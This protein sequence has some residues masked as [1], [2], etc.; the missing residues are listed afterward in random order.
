VD[1]E[2]EEHR[3]R[4]STDLRNQTDSLT[5]SRLYIAAVDPAPGLAYDGDHLAVAA[6]LTVEVYLD[7]LPVHRE[8]PPLQD[9]DVDA[10][11]LSQVG[12][13][14]FPSKVFQRVPDGI[15]ESADLLRQFREI[16]RGSFPED[17]LR[18][19]WYLLRKPTR[20]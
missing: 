20:C 18:I 3:H 14:D 4:P 1:H 6:P 7:L 12:G 17:P 13:G 16:P 8:E 10:V 11:V 19:P 9:G 15:R 5:G 2:T